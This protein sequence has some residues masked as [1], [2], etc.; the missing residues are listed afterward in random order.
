MAYRY[1]CTVVNTELKDI[2]YYSGTGT[3]LNKIYW[4]SYE[5]KVEPMTDG[6]DIILNVSGFYPADTSSNSTVVK[7]CNWQQMEYDIDGGEILYKIK[8]IEISSV[9]ARSYKN[10]K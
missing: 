9:Y 3:Y 1:L 7:R 8:L 6:E 2:M 4:I 5:L 10:W